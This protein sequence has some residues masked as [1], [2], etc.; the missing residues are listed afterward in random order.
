LSLKSAFCFGIFL[1]KPN[2]LESVAILK[3]Y[4]ESTGVGSGNHIDIA[5]PEEIGYRGF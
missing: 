2:P 4:I 5:D 1:L 3:G